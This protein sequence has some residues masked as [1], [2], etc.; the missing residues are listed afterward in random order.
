MANRRIH[1]LE[2]TATTLDSGAYIAV[3]SDSYWAAKKF[4]A[5][6]LPDPTGA[7][8]GY[9]W[10]AD[11]ADGAAWEAVSGGASDVTDL[12]T[13]TG[14]ST[15]MVRV[16]AAGGLEYRTVAQVLSDIGALAA[17]GSVTGATSQAQAFTSGVT[18]GANGLDVNPGSDINAD[19]ITVGV[20]GAPTLSWNESGD[21]FSFSKSVATSGNLSA[22]NLTPSE[23]LY[24][25]NDKNFYWYDSGSTARRMMQLGTDNSLNIGHLDTGWGNVTNVYAG[26]VIRFYVA[27]ATSR[28]SV[29]D[30][31]STGWMVG[32]IG[33]AS[34]QLHVDQSSATA[35]VPV[36]LLD[37]ADDS[38]EMIE[39]TGTVGT[40]N[41]IEA[42]GAK[43]LT[44]THFIKVTI[45][46]VGTRYIPVGTIA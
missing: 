4:A 43:T 14:S 40:G 25:I 11:G 19:L 29:G 38:E 2:D 17:T 3:D 16:A 37:Q 26:T 6:K 22:S 41:A 36:L 32:A 7:T 12:T 23:S 18:T 13:T 30:I 1:D 20:T 44:T 5:D 33:A 27:G 9:V 45:T 39:F 35:A 15:N 24:F 42:V 31:R 8:D 10:T 21:R 28:A 34:A 46:G